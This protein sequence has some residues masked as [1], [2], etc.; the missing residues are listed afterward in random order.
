VVGVGGEDEDLFVSRVLAVCERFR[1]SV[2]VLG[3]SDSVLHLALERNDR[4]AEVREALGAVAEVG[5][6]RGRTV[7]SLVSEDLAASSELVARVS[8]AA[9][10]LEPRLVTAGAACPVIRCL[11][12][13]EDATAVIAALHRRLFEGTP[14]TAEGVG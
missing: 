5:L 8:E 13:E 12:E 3:M 2:M 10:G 4:L 6:L 14:E 11:V 7:V 9:R 1:P